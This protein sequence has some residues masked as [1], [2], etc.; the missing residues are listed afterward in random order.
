MR[1]IKKP[2]YIHMYAYS[3]P[4]YDEA[5]G[6]GKDEICIFDSNLIT[7]KLIKMILKF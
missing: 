5:I 1:L 7:K 4:A 6:N 2:A 3:T